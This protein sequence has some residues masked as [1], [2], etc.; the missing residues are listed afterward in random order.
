GRSLITQAVAHLPQP[1]QALSLDL[2]D[3][4]PSVSFQRVYR[5][6]YEGLARLLPVA[7]LPG[8]EGLRPLVAR[9]HLA[10]LL[11]TLTCAPLQGA[12][13]KP[14]T[15]WALPQG[16]PTSAA[17]LNLA[18][19]DLDRGVYKLLRAHPGV[20]LRYTR[21]IDDLTITATGGALP[22]GLTRQLERLIER[23]GFSSQPLKRR[24]WRVGEGPLI[25]CGLSLES[26]G[27]AFGPDLIARAATLSALGAPGAAELRGLAAFARQIYA[28]TPPFLQSWAEAAPARAW[29]SPRAPYLRYLQGDPTAAAPGVAQLARWLDAPMAQVERALALLEAGAAYA[30]W[31]L[32]KGG[33]GEREIES[34]AAPLKGLQTRILHRLISRAPLSAAAHGFAEGRSIA[35]NARAHLGAAALLNVDIEDAFP[36]V[37]AQRVR[38]ALDRALGPRLASLGPSAEAASEA[39]GLLTR[40]LT[41]RGRL[42]QGAPTSGA[43]FNLC[44]TPLDRLL[45]D[46]CGPRGI[47]Y[48]RY[49]DDLTF[50]SPRVEAI[51]AA[52]GDQIKQIIH[53]AG[54]RWSARKW[55][56]MAAP[57][58]EVCGVR[59]DGAHLRLSRAQL[60]RYRATLHRL[61][62]APTLDAE[63]RDKAAGILGFVHMIYGELPAPLRGP[64]QALRQRHRLE[65][66]PKSK[67]DLYGRG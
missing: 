15:A 8:L 56:R 29:S 52:F 37:S 64:A 66:K 58:L 57:R 22:E 33:G 23:V 6:F 25:I 51:D 49:A 34:P 38:H 53:R 28:Q 10:H 63:G 26:G 27:V 46:A 55:A 50:S 48:T 24:A 20:D 43:L 65:P 60:Q 1:R 21:Y 4:Y 13:P 39:L 45:E 18:C 40:L 30:T 11:A 61:A 59:L 31:R 17:L 41:Y 19:A 9:D 47:T 3:A 62:H 44:L 2:K 42:P 16:A 12:R 67:L 54:F 14:K 32:S 36:S 35:T 7:R 5:V